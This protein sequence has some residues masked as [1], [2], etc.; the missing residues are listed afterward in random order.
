MYLGVKFSYNGAFKKADLYASQQAQKSMFSLISK[1]RALNL[2]LDIQIDLFDKI[3][4][5]VAL[6]G[7]EV[8]GAYESKI[9]NRTQLK[10]LKQIL[11]LKKCTSTNMVLGETGKLPLDTIIRSRVLNFWYKLVTNVNRFKLTVVLYRILY[12]LDIAGSYTY[13]WIEY[14]RKSLNELGLSF[15]WLRQDSLD[16]KGFT[17]FKTA[18][19]LRIADQFKNKWHEEVFTS[20]NCTIYRVFKQE[21]R[22][23]AFL[24]VLPK[25]LA[26]KML[27]F[28]C[29]NTRFPVVTDNYVNE[30]VANAKCN[31]CD[32]GLL[33]DE[34][35]LILE[36]DSFCNDRFLYLGK[37]SFNQFNTQVF[38]KLLT[39]NDPR[40]LVKLAKFMSV[41]MS[42]FK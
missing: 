9:V 14:V 25:N 38:A 36:C 11:R 21:I 37:R 6:Y 24:K 22:L 7:S 40:R 31:K 39:D 17:S 4:Q 33:C 30:P 23:E 18:V 15:Y 34:L 19:K 12:K 3:V 26:L 5:P 2:D 27:K 35:H 13:P 41:I 10:Y 28:R 29:R 8:W 32:K 42:A 16:L 20:S 1:S